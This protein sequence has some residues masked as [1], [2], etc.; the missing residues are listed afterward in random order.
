MTN[1]VLH[2]AGGI[3]KCI[4]ATAV[5][6]AIKRK[7]PDDKLIV[8]SGYPDVFLGNPHVSRT[9]AFG[10]LSYFY[11]D[12]IEGK[13]CRVFAHDPYLETTHIKNEQHLIKT[14]CEMFDVPY[15]G[16]LPK[17]YLTDREINYFK[18]KFQT[19]K[20]IFV[21][22]TNGGAPG[23]DNKYS[24]ARDIP[25]SI[26]KKVI[27]EFKDE[28]TIAHVRRDDQ[29][30]FEDTSHV[31]DNFRS[32]AVLLHLSKKRLLMDSFGQHAAAAL[33]L[34]STVLWIANKPKVFGYDIHDNIRANPETLEPELRGSV[35][36]KYNIAGD[37]LEFPYRSEDEI[38][39]LEPILLSLRAQGDDPVFEEAPP[40]TEHKPGE[41]KGSKKNSPIKPK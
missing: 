11:T 16:S 38:F 14:W 24:W 19:D 29:P 4:A 40:P 28:F 32:I 15:D 35:F 22:Q 39:N 20:P 33:G 27:A 13:D 5:C 1:I 17:I 18:N 34:Q 10:T 36:N 41:R 6:Q 30:A 3:G 37:P 31:Q 2:I 25:A 26:T 23:Q 21:L 7:F 8:I 9:F 12:Y